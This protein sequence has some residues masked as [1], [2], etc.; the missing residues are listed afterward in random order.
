MIFYLALDEQSR[1]QIL[2][3]QADARA[4]N[5]NFQQIDIPVDKTGLMIW[6][7]QMLDETLNQVKEVTGISEAVTTPQPEPVPLVHAKDIAQALEQ[8]PYAERTA[9]V[10]N[11]WEQLPLARKFH[12]AAM[13]MED[14]REIL[15]KA[16]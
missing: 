15:G 4:V 6:V 5:K 3:T 13:A 8:I 11:L 2:G 9:I 7:Q 14:G 16:A 12:F 1:T 10:D